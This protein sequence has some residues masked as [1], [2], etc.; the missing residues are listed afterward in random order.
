MG[1]V[2]VKK[3]K[4]GTIKQSFIGEP[5]GVLKAPCRQT[6]AGSGLLIHRKQ[7]RYYSK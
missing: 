2:Y 4:A 7:L 5:I 3:E 6:T 1:V